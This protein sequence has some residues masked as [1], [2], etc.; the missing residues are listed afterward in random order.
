MAKKGEVWCYD[1]TKAL[2]AAQGDR[3]VQ[4]KVD[5]QQRNADICSD[6]AKTP[7]Q[8]GLEG[9]ERKQCQTKTK[10]LKQEYKEYKDNLAKSGNS[11]KKPPPFREGLDNFLGDRREA[12]GRE[13]AVDTF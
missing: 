12:T 8:E 10:H 1:A 5:G 11:R 6:T 9:S 2:I 13:N 7:Q 3:K 4:E